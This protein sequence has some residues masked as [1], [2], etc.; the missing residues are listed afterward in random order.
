MVVVSFVKIGFF[1]FFRGIRC[2]RG[3]W[4][5]GG[6]GFFFGVLRCFFVFS[7]VRGWEVFGSVF[8]LEFSIC[9]LLYIGV[10]CYGVSINFLEFCRGVIF[11][12][13][14]EDRE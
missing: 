10:G 7:V 6:V 11:L 1:F 3:I 8:F 12:F 2:S 13:R 4:A 9:V 5:G 14:G